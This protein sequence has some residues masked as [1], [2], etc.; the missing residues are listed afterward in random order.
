MSNT[1]SGIIT[2]VMYSGIIVRVRVKLSTGD[3]IVVKMA[4]GLKSHPFRIND[5]VT[6]IILPENILVYPYPEKGLE[7][8]LALE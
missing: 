2:D 8:E 4:L 6:I 3:L 5:N 7:M 1:L